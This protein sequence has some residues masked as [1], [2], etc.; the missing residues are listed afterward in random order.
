MITVEQFCSQKPKEYHFLKLRGE[1]HRVCNVR[2]THRPKREYD[3]LLG[4]GSVRIAFEGSQELYPEHARVTL[5]Q[6]VQ[7]GE[8]PL[9]KALAHWRGGVTQQ[10]EEQIEAVLA[11][12]GE[13]VQGVLDA[14]RLTQRDTDDGIE[15]L[16]DGV[17]IL[18]RAFKQ[19]KQ[20]VSVRFTRPRK[21]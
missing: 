11:K 5:G 6:F 3:V 8:A 12:R 2:K 9:S 13:D 21:A 4:D 19:G 1:P 10:T 17:V 7:A 16:L 18:R 15:Y 20:S 14:S